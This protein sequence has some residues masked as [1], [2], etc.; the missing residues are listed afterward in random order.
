M[1]ASTYAFVAASCAPVGSVT[2]VILE[3]ATSTVPDPF[4]DNEI[5]PLVSVLVRALPSSL[6]LSILY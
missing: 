2:L 3:V 6:K 4:G 5:L 1:T